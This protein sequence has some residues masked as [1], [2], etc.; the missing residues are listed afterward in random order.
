MVIAITGASGFL[1]SFLTRHIRSRYTSVIRVLSS[2]KSDN[3]S[4][5]VFF[6]LE[7]EQDTES[8]DWLIGVDTLIHCAARAHIMNESATDPL[9]EY[10][11]VNTE[12]TLR[13]ASIAAEKGVRRFIYISS[14]KV[15][16]ERNHTDNS[17]DEESQLEPVDPYGISKL[18]AEIG[19]REIAQQ[20]GMEVVI[21]RPPLIYGPGVKANFESMMKWLSKDRPLPLGAVNNRRSL[22]GIDNLCNFIQLCIEHPKAANETF[23]ISDQDD[24]S[25]TELLIRLKNAMNSKSVI[26]PVPTSLMKLGA[27]IVGKGTVAQRLFDNLFVTS[28]KASRLLGWTPPYTMDEQLQKTADHFLKR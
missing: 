27:T 8:C 23:L 17:I 12:G 24:V 25:T 16:G 1:G 11:K 18:E 5:C 2:R 13:L 15:H 21:I 26:L 6:E 28:D 19:L 14:I 20:T 3:K 4:D 22:V 7:S 10:R 9:T